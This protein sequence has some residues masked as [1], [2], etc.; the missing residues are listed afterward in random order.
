M[1]LVQEVRRVAGKDVAMYSTD[2][3]TWV[4]RPS[5]LKQWEEKLSL[6]FRPLYRDRI[7]KK[8]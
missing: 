3:R 8:R 7:L 2:R 1:Q 4:L 5:E 6:V